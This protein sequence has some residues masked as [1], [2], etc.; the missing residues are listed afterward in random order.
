MP[1]DLYDAP[2]YK[3]ANAEGGYDYDFYLLDS[4]IDPTYYVEWFD[5]LRKATN[6]DMVTIHINNCGGDAYTAIQLCGALQV[7][8]ATT[9]AS[10]E[11][12]CRSAATFVF[13][14]C[15][16]KL[17]HPHTD[18]MIHT[19]SGGS[20]GKF[21]DVQSQVAFDK[22]WSETFIRDYYKDLLTAAEITSVIEGKELW[23]TSTE[24]VGRLETPVKKP[25]TRKKAVADE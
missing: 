10:L 2:M 25:R 24:L 5:I 13:L 17:V 6:R 12:M 21:P 22:V 23:L 8:E 16:N 7:T 18:F 15:E 4:V 14:A 19:A 20:V 1:N 11:G 9:V 3:V